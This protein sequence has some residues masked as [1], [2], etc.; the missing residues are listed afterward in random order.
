MSKARH[1]V[2][3]VAVVF[4]VGL[5]AGLL[6]V[7]IATAAGPAKAG[8]TFITSYLNLPKG[9]IPG[10]EGG[11]SDDSDDR[12]A[13]SANGRFVAFVAAANTLSRAA[14][15]DVVN[16]FRKDRR[17]G[18][19]VFVSRGTGVNGIAPARNSHTL[20]ISGN[21][22]LVAF[23][24]DAP[25]APV[26]VDTSEDVYIR[27]LTT[28]T[29]R[30]A[31]PNTGTDIENYDISA[32]GRFIAF[33]SDEPL[34]GTDVNGEKDVFRRNLGTGAIE[35]VSRI[36]AAAT[37]GDS[38]SDVPSI[39]GDGRW[40]A[41]ASNS[42]DIAAGFVDNNGSGSDVMARDMTA[43]QTY[44]VSCR[45][46][47]LNQGANG[48]SD[49]PAIAGSPV[50]SNE[51]RIAY[52][53]Y[54]TILAAVP[55]DPSATSSVYLKTSLGAAPSILVSQSTGGEN[56]NSRAHTPR[57]DNSG[58]LVFF[59]SDASNLGA[60]DDYYGAYLRDVAA[61]TTTLG[62]ADNDYAIASDIS[63]VGNLIVWGEAGGITPDSDPDIF[64]VFTRRIPGGPVRFASRP[65][66][67]RPFRATSAYVAPSRDGVR[68]ISA[69]GRYVVMSAFSRQLSPGEA[70]QIFRRDLR[71]GRI[72][73]ASRRS[74]AK[75]ARSDGATAPS[76][77]NDGSRVAFISY[78]PLV[79]ADADSDPD[80]YVR[81]FR[82]RTTTLVSR[83]DGAAGAD[84][85]APVASV[86]ISGN[87]RRVAFETEATNLGVLAGVAQVYVR[88]LAAGR[89]VLASRANGSGGDAGNDD[90]T[91]ASISNDGRVVAFRSRATNL[92]PD[93]A[94]PQ[95][96]VYVRNLPTN[97]TLLASRLP[98]LAGANADV[99]FH[100]PALSGDGKVVAF[101]SEDE[102]LVPGTGPWPVGR[103]Q[104][105]TRVLSNGVNKLASRSRG[106][107]AANASADS[108][109]L[110]RDGSQVAFE[111]DSTNLLPKRGGEVRTAV[112]VKN[113]R[114]GRVAGPPAFGLVDNE[115]QQG[116][117][118][119]SLS[120]NGRCL[121]FV[122]TG[123]NRASGNSS[124]INSSYVY[125]VSGT[126]SNPRGIPRPRI[127][128]VSVKGGRKA[129]IRF[130]LNAGATITATFRR[131]AGRRY[132]GAGKL[133]RKN[134]KAGRRTLR[135]RLRP[136][137]YRVTLIAKNA[138]GRSRAVTR[139]F[140][141]RR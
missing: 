41:F 54:A 33:A 138:A 108:P 2:A 48:E 36:P 95:R 107:A 122:A 51:V 53:S 125:T 81:D 85:N 40:V 139:S 87:G 55:I 61:G 21:G 34:A 98:G 133:V 110:N 73:L 120:D 103:N 102:S 121:A 106:G 10:G 131:R 140:R 114:T 117:R 79:A 100:Q 62:S 31:T 52:R 92:D 18:A 119:P 5:V 12:S 89:T 37:A 126:C 94:E 35:L 39:S 64:G 16:I 77:S 58:N 50:A 136:G 137:K 63:A 23:I 68:T 101:M 17:T 72:E 30:L 49:E 115:P 69:N 27:N 99:T 105:V 42:N 29:T 38:Y 32:D 19:V 65:K 22:N 70:N 127:S 116:A 75:G 59:S 13:L 135:K 11:Y 45:F 93:D 6:S 47:N 129:M 46:D 86:A 78:S 97:T 84:A 1:S 90:S 82:N 44:L 71:T 57:I 74:G 7:G 4:A 26:D 43:G 66:G 24:T 28:R 56:A 132:V 96:D 25:L 8:S 128:G 112:F 134:Q 124:D 113:M 88:D 15:P 91:S 67:N 83:A 9:A 141:V 76:I 109:S 80:V 123:H 104:V 130:R 20:R 60:G 118:S 14:N 3:R 111:S